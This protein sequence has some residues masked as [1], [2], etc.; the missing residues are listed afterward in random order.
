MEAQIKTLKQ[1]N[2]ELGSKIAQHEK[3][4]NT[5]INDAKNQA[6]NDGKNGAINDCKPKIDEAKT[7]A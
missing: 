4:F 3:D 6:I 2:D 7:A 1:Q 5:K